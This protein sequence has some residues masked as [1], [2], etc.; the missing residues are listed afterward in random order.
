MKTFFISPVRG[1]DQKENE[2]WVKLLEDNGYQVHWPYRDT[3]QSDDIGL[4]IC[5]E[6][7]AAIRDSDVVHIVWDGESQGCL[8]DAGMSFALGKRIIPLSLPDPTN[9]KSFQK[10][11]AEYARS[12]I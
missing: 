6:N 11:V 10:M 1:K 3:D 12:N 4:R 5:F 8:F 2:G 7:L 9:E